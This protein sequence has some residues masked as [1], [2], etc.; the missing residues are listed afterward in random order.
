MDEIIKSEKYS[1]Y[2]ESLNKLI[3]KKGTRKYFKQTNPK[4]LG[5]PFEIDIKLIKKKC[6]IL[7]LMPNFQWI[8]EDVNALLKR[9]NSLKSEYQSGIDTVNVQQKQLKSLTSN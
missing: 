9:L 6:K 3:D 2:I 8:D 7:F 1:P 4:L 5:T